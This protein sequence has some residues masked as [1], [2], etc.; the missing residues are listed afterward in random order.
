MHYVQHLL[1]FQSIII[2]MLCWYEK[3][4]S[5]VSNCCLKQIQLMS[6]L[7]EKL[8]H[9]TPCCQPWPSKTFLTK[10]WE[11]NWIIFIHFLFAVATW[12]VNPKWGR[13]N[14]KIR[15]QETKEKSEDW[16]W[17]WRWFWCQKI[18]ASVKEV[19]R[20]CGVDIIQKCIKER[21]GISVSA[22]GRQQ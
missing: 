20:C 15:T 2:S 13:T 4:L 8:C 21:V 7:E 14:S 12:P 18:C 16:G 5:K 6:K 3:T 17:Y 1:H 19:N 10:M 9:R 22:T 11:V